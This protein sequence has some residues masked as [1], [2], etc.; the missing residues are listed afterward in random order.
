MSKTA[1]ALA[2]MVPVF[3]VSAQ[4]WK[5]DAKDAWIDGKAE[6]V[7]LL[8]TNLNNFDINTDV[9]EGQVTLTGQVDSDVDKALASELVEGIDGVK[10]V[11]NKLTVVTPK[12]SNA[13]KAQDGQLLT[14]TKI[15]TVVKTRL[16][17]E[18]EVSGTSIDVSTK[19]GV[20]TLN[21]TLDT[22]AERDLALAIARNTDDVKKV[23]DNLEVADS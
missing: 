7:L 14:D 12:D 23:V 8:N 4:D 21:G 13:D 2:L 3:T 19:Q 18:P 5:D 16:L 9:T 22:S 6:T 11:K 15:T 1:I 20:V 17:F 10:S